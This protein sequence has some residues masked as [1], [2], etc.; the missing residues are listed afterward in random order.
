MHPRQEMLRFVRSYI[1]GKVP[2]ACFKGT[3]PLDNM[4]ARWSGDD[5]AQ[6]LEARLRARFG[7]SRTTNK[8]FRPVWNVLTEL[9]GK[10]FIV[11]LT[12]SRFEADEWVLLV[13]ALDTP[14]LF[15][16][17]FGRKSFEYIPKLKLVTGEI[18]MLLAQMAGISRLRWYFEGA[19]SSVATPDELSWT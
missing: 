2:H 6:A 8:W 10:R 9:S 17:V 3:F 15:G 1:G 5:L 12:R 16:G 11:C 19:D 4:P 18:H 13:G 7:S 14:F